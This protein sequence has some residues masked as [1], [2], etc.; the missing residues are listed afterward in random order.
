MEEGR[1]N[2]LESAELSFRTPNWQVQAGG[3][4]GSKK[5]IS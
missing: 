2:Q 5:V 4:H 3:S 1:E